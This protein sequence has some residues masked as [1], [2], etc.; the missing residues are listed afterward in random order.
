MTLLNA[1]IWQSAADD[2]LAVLLTEQYTDKGTNG[3]NR[4]VHEC[5]LMSYHLPEGKWRDLMGAI[6]DLRLGQKAVSWNNL[7]SI[8]SGRV[9]EQWYTE[10]VT[11]CDVTR[12][13]D[14]GDNVTLL[15]D[16][17]SRMAVVDSLEQAAKDLRDGDANID[18]RVNLLV[19]DITTV[20]ET[21]IVDETAGDSDARLALVFDAEPPPVI[22]TGIGF[23]DDAIGGLR[24]QRMLVLAG[25][26]KSRKTT[27]M[28]NW[29]L[30]AYRAGK[31]PAVLSWENTITM[32]MMQL[33]AMLAVEWLIQCGR[34]TYAPDAPVFW[35]SADGLMQ[36]GRGYKRWAS[37]K[38][39]ALDYARAELKRMGDGMRFYDRTPSGGGLSDLPSARAVIRRDMRLYGGDVFGLDHQGLIDA[40]GEVFE[41]TRSVSKYL[42]GLSRITEPHS[43]SLIVL[44]QLNENAIANTSG[45]SAGVK[46]GGDTSANA[47]YVLRTTP[48]KLPATEDKYYD[49][50][51]EL[52]VKH[53][54]WGATTAR[55][56][57][58]FHPESG[59]VM[60]HQTV[61]FDSMVNGK[62]V[63]P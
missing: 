13:A 11:L 41:H 45:Y 1:S 61:T 56:I 39:E 47:D 26:Y 22:P 42:Q 57:V 30:R 50:R 10:L 33:I 32:T 18:E 46:G 2:V 5:G 38:V 6:L 51:I 21:K 37:L 48:V 19:S 44:A 28:L 40:N 60:P 53:N 3:F 23:V 62:K 34:V 7:A 63:H 27:L 20:G 35:I 36:A 17:G 14:F 4:A 43:I 29:L 12:I 49:D 58:M 31:R 8:L 25:A 9:T 59:L 52:Q 54:R 55:E 15:M 24:E 16:Y